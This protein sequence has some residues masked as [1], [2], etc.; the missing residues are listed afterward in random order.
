MSIEVFEAKSR[1]KLV[2]LAEQSRESIAGESKRLYQDNQ[3]TSQEGVSKVSATRKLSIM[4]DYVLDL[5]DYA[6]TSNVLSNACIELC[7]L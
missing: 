2:E 1:A 7:I 6:G 3:N 5:A 4:L